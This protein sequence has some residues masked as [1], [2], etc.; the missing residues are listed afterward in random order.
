[1]ATVIES[2]LMEIGVDVDEKSLKSFNKVT[3]GTVKTL[4]RVSVAAGAAGAA[5]VA[6]AVSMARSTDENAK[7]AEQTG[8]SFQAMQELGFAAEREGA[9]MDSLK[10]SLAGLTKA[11]GEVASDGSE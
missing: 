3:E 7:F 1:M 9:S 6:Y 5:V 8:V 4:K 11:A 2:L 10:S